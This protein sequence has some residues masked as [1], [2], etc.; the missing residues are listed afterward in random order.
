VTIQAV[1]SH[2]ANLTPHC[3]QKQPS[4]LTLTI[5]YSSRNVHFSVLN[6]VTNDI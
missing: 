6:E 1:E 2:D 4:A 5:W 3:P